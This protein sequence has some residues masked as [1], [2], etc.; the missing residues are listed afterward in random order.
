MGSAVE[1][2]TDFSAAA[3]RKL[4]KKSKDNNQARRLL[5]LAAVLAVALRTWQQVATAEMV[6]LARAAV[7]RARE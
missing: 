5:A 3:L 1:L 6:P 2:R 7:A 4:A